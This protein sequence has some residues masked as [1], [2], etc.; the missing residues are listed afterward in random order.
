MLHLFSVFK[1]L[2]YGS[3]RTTDEKVNLRQVNVELAATG[4]GNVG[5][6]ENRCQ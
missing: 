5:V 6:Q 4:G 1:W 3:E 2:K